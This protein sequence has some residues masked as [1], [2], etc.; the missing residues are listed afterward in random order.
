MAESDCGTMQIVGHGEAHWES[1]L[2]LCQAKNTHV[3][4]L[5]AIHLDVGQERGMSNELHLAALKAHL[6][7][8][9]D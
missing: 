2:A 1:K 6:D 3:H 4:A 5:G 8:F 9:L 7:P